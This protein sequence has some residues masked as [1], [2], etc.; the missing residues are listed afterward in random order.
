M[1]IPRGWQKQ[2]FWMG[3]GGV[4][5]KKTSVGEYGFFLEPRI[6]WA[7]LQFADY[8]WTRSDPPYYL[9]IQNTRKTMSNSEALTI[10]VVHILCFLFS[11]QEYLRITCAM[12]N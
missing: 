8:A 1:Q 9:P 4:Y 6:S 5:T 12:L 7:N 2:Y 11:R 10:D 3:E